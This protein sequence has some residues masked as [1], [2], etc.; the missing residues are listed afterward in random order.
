MKTRFF[1][2]LAV[3]A[4]AVLMSFASCITDK[5]PEVPIDFVYVN[6]METPITMYIYNS[7]PAFNDDMPDEH[8]VI[9][10]GSSLVLTT[11]YMVLGLVDGYVEEAAI[12]FTL[13]YAMRVK[14]NGEMLEYKNGD[15]NSP[16][17]IRA[18]APSSDGTLT[19]TYV[20]K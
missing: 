5:F 19:Y 7:V 6:V 3:V 4:T 14:F 15:R 16:F 11:Q 17:D 8:Y 1:T 13:A 12:P 20:F 10:P 18:Y 9:D 2:K